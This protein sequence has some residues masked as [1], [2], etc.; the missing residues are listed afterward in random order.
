MQRWFD[1]GISFNIHKSIRK[2]RNIF[3]CADMAC[4]IIK[5]PFLILKTCKYIQQ[6]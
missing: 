6:F 5:E 1:I 4:H 2:Y 3:I